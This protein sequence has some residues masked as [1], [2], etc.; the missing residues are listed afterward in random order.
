MLGS[1]A[2]EVVGDRPHTGPLGPYRRD[3]TSLWG[4]WESPKGVRDE[5]DPV[6]IGSHHSSFG[7]DHK[8]VR[9]KAGSSGQEVI[10][11]SRPKREWRIWAAPI[12]PWGGVKAEND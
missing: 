12:A 2:G 1:G 7:G 4:L 10:A 6:F 5:W 9:A 8:T 11:T 3:L